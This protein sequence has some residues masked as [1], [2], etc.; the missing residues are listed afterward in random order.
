MKIQ[1]NAFVAVQYTLSLDSGEVVDRSDPSDPL[2]FLCGAGHIIPGFERALEGLSAGE[3]KKFVLEASDGYGERSD[4]MLLEVPLSRFPDDVEIKP[5]MTFHGPGGRTF[6][7][8][9]VKG[10]VVTVDANHP[11]A[12]ERLHFDVKVETVREPT[13]ED[14]EAFNGGCGDGCCSGCGHHGESGGCC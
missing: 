5:G 12:G 3:A 7:V 2:T 10:D 13:E 1:N 6:N 11:L 4:D 14:L 9:G 8:T